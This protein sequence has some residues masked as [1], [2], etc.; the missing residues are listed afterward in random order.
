MRSDIVLLLSYYLLVSQ[1]GA[2]PPICTQAPSITFRRSNDVVRAEYG[3]LI[4]A[5]FTPLQC[6]NCYNFLRR[7]DEIGRMNRQAK[8]LIIAPDFESNHIISRTQS[9][10][11][12]VQI[13]RA[14]EGWPHYNAKNFDILIIDQCGK[15]A[16][17]IEWPSSDVTMSQKVSD[18]VREASNGP[19][20]GRCQSDNYYSTKKINAYIKER[21]MRNNYNYNRQLQPPAQSALRNYD[22]N[23]NNQRTSPS[24]TANKAQVQPNTKTTTTTTP[25]TPIDYS[26]YYEADENTVTT[27]SPQTQIP[28]PP[29]LIPNWP[30]HSPLN[31]NGYPQQY[32]PRHPEVLADANLPCSAYTD[33][34]CF[35]QHERLGLPLSKCCTKGIYLT[36][37]CVPGKCSNSTQRMCCFQKF[38]Q[39]KYACCND[40]NQDD[41]ENPTNKFNKCCYDLFVNEDD[42]CPMR[43]SNNYWKTVYDVC[44][45]KTYVNFSSV[46]F[47]VHFNEGVRVLDLSLNRQ[48]DFNCTYGKNVSQ[49]AYLP[50]KKPT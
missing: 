17:T 35:H 6:A 33:D 8:I 3:K 24:R 9:A 18:V 47:E 26:D 38:L 40:P 30:T 43:S 45:P 28:K 37:V 46:K 49:Y 1:S 13:D 16:N 31:L 42:C 34:I 15:I 27:V 2:L 23:R 21:D 5:V 25:Q 7:L 11:T 36:D 10:F 48:W 44:F 39:A 50:K 29:A 19:I 32:Q 41:A 14:A 22:P 4:V 12:S 20:C